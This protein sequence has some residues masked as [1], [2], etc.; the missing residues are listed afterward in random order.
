MQPSDTELEYALLESLFYNEMMILGDDFDFSAFEQETPVGNDPIPKEKLMLP[1]SVSSIDSAAYPH[2][3]HTKAPSMASIVDTAHG[4]PS[5]FHRVTEI[6]TAGIISPVIQ[7]T[8]VSPN[9]KIPNEP[10]SQKLPAVSQSF[11]MAPAVAPYVYTNNDGKEPFASK[12]TAPMPDLS[13]NMTPSVSDKVI[14]HASSTILS[15]QDH[16]ASKV[17]SQFTMLASRLGIQLPNSIMESLTSSVLQRVHSSMPN[18]ST[19]S[20]SE[21]SNKYPSE[22]R[23]SVAPTI[24][25]D[26]SDNSDS[27][28]HNEEHEMDEDDMA[29]GEKVSSKPFA[30]TASQDRDNKRK[31]GA[32]S[33]SAPSSAQASMDVAD[34]KR[35]SHK[36]AGGSFVRRKKAPRLEECEK[37]LAKL[38]A[39]NEMLKR[40]H[41]HVTNK[42]NKLDQE[43]KEMDNKI[44]DIVQCAKEKGT[45]APSVAQELNT[46]LP[47]FKEMYSDY[48]NNRKDELAFHLNQLEKLA[49]PA[50][51]TKMSLWTLGQ[52]ESFYTKPKL[53]P[54]AGILR[55][56]LDITPV[57]G[58]KIIS[59]REK[60]QRLCTNIKQCLALIAKLKTLCEH[61][62]RIF[63]D[64]LS[65]VQEILSPLQVAKLLVWIDG[66]SEVLDGVC[67]GWGSERIP[68]TNK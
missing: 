62:Q 16:R 63:H 39:E 51:F 57:Q 3:K 25:D 12:F 40:H 4:G 17:V 23:I 10:L 27:S 53:N 61:K 64:R 36:S 29:D 6:S 2:D 38:R 33:A 50:N 15:T 47:K 31:R 34:S 18:T 37:R 24:M 26:M 58:R 43:R 8:F 55:K 5:Y 13:S 35:A 22:P 1:V 66:H 41:V 32:E 11:H 59:Q 14:D 68:T 48:G 46:I 9:A 65:K 67:P 45:L 7:N 42:T 49:V 52:N 30:G 44:H 20:S 60:V 28:S 56:E 21:G 19:E 54:I